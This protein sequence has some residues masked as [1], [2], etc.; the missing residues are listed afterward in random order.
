MTDNKTDEK[1][2]GMKPLSSERGSE[3][4]ELEEALKSVRAFMDLPNLRDEY[5][6]NV[7]YG[8]IN[9]ALIQKAQEAREECIEEIRDKAT[10]LA[11]DTSDK[12]DKLWLGHLDSVLDR[13]T[14]SEEKKK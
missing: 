5:C 9:K 14:E 11:I 4:R 12:G 3:L 1:S 2:L 8:I 13:L 7:R 10:T 6:F